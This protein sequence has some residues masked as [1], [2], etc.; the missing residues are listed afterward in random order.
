MFII[1]VL[2]IFEQTLRAQK[3]YDHW[4]NWVERMEDY[5][6][7]AYCKLGVLKEKGWVIVL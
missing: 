4:L 7:W 1:L 6:S 2:I 3:N 5:D